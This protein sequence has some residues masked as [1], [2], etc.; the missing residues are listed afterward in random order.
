MNIDFTYQN[1]TRI[2]FGK[3]AMQYLPEELA[4]YGKNVLL[5]YGR[6]SIKASGLYDAVM[7]DLQKAGKKVVE[8]P[9]IKSN[10]TYAQ[11]LQGAQLVREHQVD[12]ILA[13]GGGSVIDCAKG[14]SASAYCKQD[15]WTLYWEQQAPLAN[16]VVPIGTILTMT[17]TASE[18]NGGSVIT[19]DDKKLKLGRVFP[20]ETMAPKFS[21]LNPEFTYTVPQYQMISGIFD[22]FSHLMEQYFGGNDDCVSDYLL[23]GDML[24]LISAARAALKNPRDYEARSNIMW[25]ATMGLNKILAVSK[26]QDWEVHMIEHQLGAYTDCAHGIGLAIISVPYYRAV[27]KYGL[28]RFVRYAKNI[29]HVNPEGKS[30]EQVALEGI[31][32]LSKFIQELGIPQTLRE[33]GATEAMLPL[34]AESTIKG[35]GY[36]VVTTEEVL[37]ILKAC[38]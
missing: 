13:V 32:C 27:Y 8:L 38:F 1:P 6:N 20:L 12:L 36:H 15:P 21:I 24:A 3:S 23:E 4:L 11:V 30:D 22:I 35:G 14:I 26:E 10:P 33:V 2:H 18:M 5:L 16:P 9:G 29:W 19:N 17:G 25:C 31:D 37:E 34:I 7:S 28:H